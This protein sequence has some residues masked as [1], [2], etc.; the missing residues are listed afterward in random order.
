MIVNKTPEQAERELIYR[1]LL[2]I[3]VALEDLKRMM[4][5]YHER[6]IGDLSWTGPKGKEIYSQPKAPADDPLMTIQ[7]LE[8]QQIE[9]ALARFHNNRRKVARALGIGE[10][11]LY[12]KLK[13]YGLE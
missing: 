4:V 11:T 13:E 1:A 10:R 6:S 2:D 5:T 7:D 3:R 8:K 12:R 9:K